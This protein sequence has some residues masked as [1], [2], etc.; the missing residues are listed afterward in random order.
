M[1]LSARRRGA[2]LVAIVAAALTVALVGAA[3]AGATTYS[4]S[5]T[6][7]G[8][9]VIASHLPANP[10]ASGSASITANDATNQVCATISW[11][12][13]ASPVVAGHIHEGQYGVPE[14]PAVT[15]NLFGPNLSGAPNPV[16]GCTIVPGPVMKEL[17]RFPEYFNVVVHNKQYPAGAIRGQLGYGNI[18]CQAA[19]GLCPGPL[20]NL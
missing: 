6:L 20:A 5:V 9:D 8:S 12:G 18:V 15:I 3:S 10:S 13:L 4:W 16:S 7:S 2:R 19:P 17:A 1:Y 11:S 14:N